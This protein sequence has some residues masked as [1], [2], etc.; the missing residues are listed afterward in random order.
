M[1]T[2]ISFVFSAARRWQRS[3]FMPRP[4]LLKIL[5][6]WQKEQTWSIPICNG[7]TERWPVQYT[8]LRGKPPSQGQ[9]ACLSWSPQAL[10][11]LK[12]SSVHPTNKGS[13]LTWMRCSESQKWWGILGYPAV[14]TTSTP[15]F[16][17]KFKLQIEIDDNGYL[18]S[19][20]ENT[21]ALRSEILGFKFYLCYLLA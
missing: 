6:E 13:K 11:R 8:G 12:M 10:L 15:S 17:T 20:V 2:I 19:H 7:Y 5:S 4:P 1:L 21:W 14:I 9:S 18:I 3:K 16:P